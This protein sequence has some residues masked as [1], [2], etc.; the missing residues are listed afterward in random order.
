MDAI[1]RAILG[2]VVDDGRITLRRLTER[3][4]LGSTA[5]RERLRRLEHSVIRGYTAIADPVLLGLPIGALTADT[6]AFEAALCDT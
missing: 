3:V 2:A 6:A 4:R 5:A 1:D